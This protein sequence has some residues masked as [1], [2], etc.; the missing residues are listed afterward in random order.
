[1]LERPAMV[2]EGHMILT[3]PLGRE[4]GVAIECNHVANANQSCLHNEIT[5]KYLDTQISS[6]LP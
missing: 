4:E 3:Q 2:L 5:I 6:E 1:M